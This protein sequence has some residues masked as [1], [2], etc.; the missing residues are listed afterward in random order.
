MR[1]AAFLLVLGLWACS[2]EEAAPPP[3]NANAIP[4]PRLAG[5]DSDV[6]AAIEAARAAVAQDPSGENW[7]R[8]GN[9]Y[10]VHDFLAEAAQCFAHAEELEPTRPVWP[11]RRGLCSIDD[12]PAEAEQHLA[13]ALLALDDHAPAHEN[14]AHV[15]ARLGREDE[16]LAHYERASALDPRAPQPETGL[17]QIYLARGEL[18]AARTHLEAAL[19]RDPRHGEAHTAVAQVYFGLGREKEAQAHAELSRT[20]PQT[21]RREDVYANPSVPPTG[22]RARTRM[23]KLLE[24]QKQFD[25]ALEQYRS[26]L[27]SNPDYY[28]A[29]AGL[30]ALLNR[31]GRSDEAVEVLREGER[32]N[33]DSAQVREDLQ[34]L[35][36]GKGLEARGEE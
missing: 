8:L 3:S 23:G 21:S 15:L 33:P 34:R 24:R 32:R 29:R 19:Q 4:L 12:D 6:V 26:A 25:Q 13:R 30:A 11:Y 22:A 14:Y 20:L 2:P 36:D 5:V 28:A 7:G 9:R 10:F 27:A 35:L 17:G 18:E 31:L 16:A 1:S